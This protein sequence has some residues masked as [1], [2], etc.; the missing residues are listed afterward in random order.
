M[1]ILRNIDRGDCELLSSITMFAVSTDLFFT[2]CVILVHIGVATTDF[3]GFGFEETS[4]PPIIK[5]VKQ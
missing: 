1:Y 2:S 3:L 5:H 4:S